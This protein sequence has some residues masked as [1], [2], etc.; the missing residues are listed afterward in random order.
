MSFALNIDGKYKDRNRSENW[1]NITS[2]ISDQVD[3]K[4]IRRRWDSKKCCKKKRCSDTS[5]STT[6]EEK[7]CKPGG[8]LNDLVD[9]NRRDQIDREQRQEAQ[10][11]ANKLK[12]IDT[13][14]NTSAT[15]E[16]DEEDIY[17]DHNVR[18][19]VRQNRSIDDN[20]NISGSEC[21]SS[22]DC[23]SDCHDKKRSS[24]S[25]DIRDS[26]VS[27]SFC[28]SSDCND[29]KKKH[30]KYRP[31]NCSKTFCSTFSSVDSV[32][33]ND[34]FRLGCCRSKKYKNPSGVK[35]YCGSSYSSS[36]H[37]SKTKECK[38]KCDFCGNK[39][40]KCKK[41]CNIY[42]R[43]YINN[44]FTNSNEIIFSIPSGFLN[45]VTYLGV[46]RDVV[47]KMKRCRICEY[48]LY[49]RDAPC[50][51]LI[52]GGQGLKDIGICN[53]VT[54]LCKLNGKTAKKLSLIYDSTTD[55]WY[56]YV[57]Y[58]QTTYDLYCAAGSSELIQATVLDTQAAIDAGLV[59]DCNCGPNRDRC[60]KDDNLRPIQDKYNKSCKC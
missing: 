50:N 3:I 40:C 18:K 9:C 38:K 41:K 12:G 16:T 37:V 1:C 26:S 42:H 58:E 44:I 60:R 36:G 35:T 43:E 15:S 2:W 22:S 29:K 56:L 14:Y 19:W 5:T 55:Q 27:S 10:R 17:I 25:R 57:E 6:Y 31:K 32:S 48:V 23:S 39:K 51:L 47:E 4:G 8:N 20:D 7:C 59:E 49:D 11:C 13:S 52:A 34:D 30:K 45:D 24:F 28:N 21:P 46:P 54:M 53:V 33:I